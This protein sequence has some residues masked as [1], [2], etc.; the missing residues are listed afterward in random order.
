MVAYGAVSFAA[1]DADGVAALVLPARIPGVAW[2]RVPDGFV[3][4]PVWARVEGKPAVELP[5]RRLAQPHRGPLT[6]V[7]AA[8]T[9]LAGVQPFA[10]RSR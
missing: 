4:G 7:V 9:H 1:T 2:V 6:F 8:D 3:P 10:E 5:L